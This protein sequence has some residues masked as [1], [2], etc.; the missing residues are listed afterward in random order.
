MHTSVV[1]PWVENNFHMMWLSS[2][3]CHS[4]H[5]SHVGLGHV[6]GSIASFHVDGGDCS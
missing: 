5:A 1:K 3:P 6:N 2:S 4:Q